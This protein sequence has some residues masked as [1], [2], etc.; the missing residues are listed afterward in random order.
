MTAGR[1]RLFDRLAA[2]RAQIDMATDEVE[3]LLG[4]PGDPTPIDEQIAEMRARLD[5]LDSR[6]HAI[7]EGSSE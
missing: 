2:A 4:G 5:A 3:H 7:E 6:V 1:K